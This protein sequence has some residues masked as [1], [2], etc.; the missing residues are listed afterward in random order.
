MTHTARKIFACVSLLTCACEDSDDGSTSGASTSITSA[1]TVPGTSTGPTTGSPTTDASTST[2]STGNPTT[3]NATTGKPP[4]ACGT[5][6]PECTPDAREWCPDLAILCEATGLDLSGTGGTNYCAVVATMCAENVPPCQVC[7]YLESTC[8]Q[9]GLL[10]ACTDLAAEC[11]CRA[12]AH[13][14]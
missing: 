5:V 2:S 4:A 9:L 6:K 11:Q 12:A 14:L 7:A 3:S 13:G 8:T 10:T 1:S